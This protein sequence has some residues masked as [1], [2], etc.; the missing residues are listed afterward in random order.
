MKQKP[1]S[2]MKGSDHMKKKM[3][4]SLYAA[5]LTCAM[6]GMTGCSAFSTD[7]S[8]D[9]AEQPAAVAETEAAEQQNEQTSGK[10]E[11]TATNVSY[12]SN[13]TARINTAEL[14]TERDLAQ[15][16]D[17]AGAQT[18]TVQ[19]GETY[20]ITTEG[21]Y[22]VKGSAS[23]C[24]I[25]VDAD[26]KAKIQLV[27]DGVTVTNSDSPAVYVVSA[28]K[29]FVTSAGENVLSVTG[30]FRADGE[31][32]TDAVIFAKSDL[33]LNGTGSLSVN[34]TANGITSKDDLKVTGGTYTLTTTEDALE[35]NDSISVC[36]GSFTIETQKDGLHCENDEGTGD[37]CIT[38]G[39]FT[40]N[41]ETDGVQATSVLQI[42]GGTFTIDASEGFEATYVQIN[43]GTIS[44]NAAD[45]GI[46]ATVKGTSREVA[47]EIN[48]GELTI[49]M[50]QGDTDGIDAN[51]SIYVNGGKIDVTAPMSS[52][53]YDD[54]AEFNGGTIIINGE[55]VSE[56]P[57]DMMG[58]FGRGGFGGFG[59]G[60]PPEGWDNENG[61]RPTP[62]NWNG[63]DGENGWGTP[64]EGW[65]NEDGGNGWGQL[66]QGW[67]EEDGGNRPSRPQGG[68]NRENTQEEV[69]AGKDTQNI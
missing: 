8:T 54:K 45:D 34:S 4:Q 56:I 36:G 42:D 32:N 2:L 52:F 18:I 50:A 58:G 5:I 22:I 46:N 31:T 37:I 57:E 7:V 60:Q 27:L 41:A 28:D 55:E 33:V 1:S 12:N 47:V 10:T 59:N 16:A 39:S 69:V 9:V 29:V 3:S 24:T 13:F 63:E 65:N 51:G 64:P 68:R 61:D 25:L 66:P 44:I 30:D 38:G 6:F 14:F 67:N 48:G 17:T 49:V 20:T 43:G 19:D 23:D 62:P 40:I 35:A 53:D 21:V 11:A 26:E 15:T